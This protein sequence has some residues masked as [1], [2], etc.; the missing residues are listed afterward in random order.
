MIEDLSDLIDA[1]RETLEVELKQWVDLNDSM[2]RAGLARHMAALCNHGGGYLVFGIGD[3]LTIDPD[4]PSS[5]DVFN[6]DTFSSI[7]K[8]YLSP[9]FQCDV[10]I[11]TG[12]TSG[13]F[14]IV[15]VPGHDIV[16]V[17]AK[18]DGPH[19]ADGRPHGIRVGAYY[20]RSPGPE[21]IAI[22]SP[23]DWSTL[24]RHC[25]LNDRDA[26]LRDITPI[27]QGREAIAP[28]AEDRLHSWHRSAESR[29]YEVL[30]AAENFSWPVPLEDNCF[31]LSYLI[32][33]NDETIPTGDLRH[34]LEE[35]NNEVRD[36]VWTGWSMF[37]PFSRPEIA[38]YVH[39][40]NLDGT[41]DDLLE[42]NLTGLTQFDTT[43]PDFWRIAPD[44]R[45]SLIR[46]YREDVRLE[47][48]VRWL[49]PENVLREAA[50]VIRHARAFSRHFPTA[51]TVSFRCTWKGLRGREL[52]DFDPAIY[53]PPGRSASAD[54]RTLT[55]DYPVVQL[56]AA[57]PKLV[58]DL[59]CPIL[60]LFGFTDCSPQ[61]VEG[62]APRFTK[63]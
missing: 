40:E 49:S 57:W 17:C 38:P 45:A 52:M 58:S 1:P 31:Q 46:G 19:G 41:G 3:D 20:I 26:L 4:R 56:N 61:L 36:T 60:Y 6:H 29:F 13:E 12:V 27:L 55:G 43:L 15:R 44:G 28:V 30:R 18:R 24:I 14:P 37:Y 59:G 47:E 10:S 7:V 16:P 33:H 23:Q 34:V 35:I 63:D 53:W 62:L 8:K 11:V 2:V 50:E 21:S 54:E 25:T 42:A 39:P 5:L 22:T 51:S 48:P 9:T 32:S